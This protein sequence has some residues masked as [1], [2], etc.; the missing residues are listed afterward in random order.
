MINVLVGKFPTKIA[1]AWAE[2]KQE[3]KVGAI[4]SNEIFGELMSFL[5][6]KKDVT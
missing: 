2:H 5:K 6:A 3:K 4:A 1:L